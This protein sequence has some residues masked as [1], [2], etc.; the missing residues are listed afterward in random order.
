V[1]K[2]L[3]TTYLVLVLFGPPRFDTFPPVS[4]KKDTTHAEQLISKDAGVLSGVNRDC[5]GKKPM[6]IPR[7]KLSV[8]NTNEVKKGV[9][10]W[11]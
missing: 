4:Q 2:K 5:G 7:R 8:D 6:L 9:H 1:T 11:R 10:H 3:V